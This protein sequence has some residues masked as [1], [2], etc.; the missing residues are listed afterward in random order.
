MKTVG[1]SDISQLFEGPKTFV[2]EL[3]SWF[4]MSLRIRIYF[5]CAPVPGHKL[6]LTS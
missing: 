5:V 4:N 3:D 2:K 6:H 1:K